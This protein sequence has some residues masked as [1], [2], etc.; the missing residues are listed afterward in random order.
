MDKPLESPRVGS[1]MSTQVHTRPGMVAFDLH[2]ALRQQPLVMI[3]ECR[4][5]C[6]LPKGGTGRIDVILIQYSV[7]T[8]SALAKN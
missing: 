2:C 3:N 8:Y 7:Y 4:F 1:S 6:Q 5:I